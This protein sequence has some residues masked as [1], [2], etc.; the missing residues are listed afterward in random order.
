VT[1][2]FIT[3]A[4]AVDRE[5]TWLQTVG[6]GLPELP[7]IAGGPFQVIEAY[8]PFIPQSKARQLYVLRS[9]IQEDRTANVRT[10]DHYPFILRVIWPL[11]NGQGNAQQDQRDMDAALDKLVGRIRGKPGDKTHGGQFLDVGE[12]P[13]QVHVQILPPEQTMPETGDLRAL[14][15][16]RAND[17]EYTA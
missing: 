1:G 7:A 12:E 17:F 14:I 8:L 3:T 9:E 4:D 10:Q 5:T 16:Y 11:S 13:R 15:T 2:R 6:D